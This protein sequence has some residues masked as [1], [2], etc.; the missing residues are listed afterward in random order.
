MTC[1]INAINS[2]AKL[3][4]LWENAYFVKAFIGCRESEPPC[5]VKYISGGNSIF[6]SLQQV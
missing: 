6:L 2:L 5:L 4:L 1:F 3:V